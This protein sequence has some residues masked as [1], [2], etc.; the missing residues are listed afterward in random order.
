MNHHLILINNVCNSK[1]TSR[2]ETFQFT[3][4]LAQ[5]TINSISIMFTQQ[6]VE[7]FGAKDEELRYPLQSPKAK[8]QLLRKID[9]CFL[10]HCKMSLC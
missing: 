2:L 4:Q 6:N 8:S 5:T 10:T 7:F 3:I 1:Q 9:Q